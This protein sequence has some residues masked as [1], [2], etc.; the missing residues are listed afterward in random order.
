MRLV[1][2]DL[3]R[4]AERRVQ[5]EQ[6]RAALGNF[7]QKQ[8]R[9]NVAVPGSLVLESHFQGIKSQQLQRQRTFQVRIAVKFD[10]MSIQGH[11]HI[12]DR[13]TMRLGYGMDALVDERIV[14]HGTSLPLAPRLAALEIAR[15]R[16]QITDQ[17]GLF[18]TDQRNQPFVISIAATSPPRR[19]G[20]KRLNGAAT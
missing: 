19:Q 4:M 11:M 20:S 6:G 14:I 18:S 3:D 8:S 9:R 15:H 10:G 17:L 2:N 5:P 7:D 16:L 13:A 1:L 12:V